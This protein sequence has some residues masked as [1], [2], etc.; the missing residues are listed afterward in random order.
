MNT[1]GFKNWLATNTNYS[2]RVISDIVSRLKR[3]DKIL[4]VRPEELYLF[5]LEHTEEF[6]KISTSVKSQI[7]KSVRLYNQFYNS[8]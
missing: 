5:E 8:K 4:S 3:A 1:V 6:N 7:R 2:D